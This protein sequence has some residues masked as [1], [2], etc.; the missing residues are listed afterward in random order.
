MRV[1]N[2]MECSE[3]MWSKPF[4]SNN[5]LGFRRNVVYFDNA[6]LS[7]VFVILLV[8]FL[9]KCYILYSICSATLLFAALTRRLILIACTNIL[10]I[11]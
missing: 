11:S 7:K 5:E 6:T 1:W 2:S 9:K 10:Y 3:N 8:E 4:N